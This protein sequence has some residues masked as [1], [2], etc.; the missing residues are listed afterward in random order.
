M[1]SRW[2]RCLV[3]ALLLTLGLGL[4]AQAKPPAAGAASLRQGGVLEG[5]AAYGAALLLA[6]K[7]D[8]LCGRGYCPTPPPPPP[9]I[10][11]MSNAV[12]K[13]LPGRRGSRP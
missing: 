4:P 3:T 10:H 1:S 5:L 6:L 11:N 7:D 9:P 12:F 13:P 2:I 8:P